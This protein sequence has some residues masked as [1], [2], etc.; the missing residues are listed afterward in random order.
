MYSANKKIRVVILMGGPSSEHEVSLSSG[1]QVLRHLD[2]NKYETKAVFIS[3]D[4]L[5]SFPSE[6]TDL[7]LEE[8]LLTLDRISPNIVF[9]ALH[10]NFGQESYMQNHLK[11]ANIPYTG[12]NDIASA[13]A[14]HKG[15][16]SQVLRA[17]NILVPEYLEIHKL[18]F[19][20]NESKIISEILKKIKSPLVVKPARHGSSVGV[21][22]VKDRGSLAHDSLKSALENAFEL[23]KLTI[24]QKYISGREFTCGIL[25][26]N[27]EPVALLPTEIIPLKAKHF[28]YESKY[29]SDGAR[30][31]TPP[32]NLSDDKI[33]EIQALALQVHQTLNLKGYSRVDMI[34]SKDQNLYVLEANTLPGLTE[35]SLLPK[36]AAALGIS[37]GGLLD[38]IIENGLMR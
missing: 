1:A 37:F 35:G 2:N 3:K 36:G 7:S 28:N 21:S 5:W 14:L 9:L 18:D 11:S 23:D 27:G 16:S 8:G 20:K 31:I 19:K 15:A 24:V 29:S 34:L 6:G 10:G 32:E 22:I 38:L 17:H 12:S 4:N 33:K 25:E 30:E 13:L 26:K